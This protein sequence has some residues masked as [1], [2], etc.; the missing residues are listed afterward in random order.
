[1][2]ASGKVLELSSRV[3]AVTLNLLDAMRDS[4]IGRPAYPDPPTIAMFL[5]K[6][7]V[8]SDS[9]QDLLYCQGMNDLQAS[10]QR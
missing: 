10:V 9:Q 4:K 1:V 8:I 3:I 2:T 5:R 7:I 6:D